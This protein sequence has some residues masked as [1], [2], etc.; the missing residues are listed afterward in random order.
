M[1]ANLQQSSPFD[2]DLG[3]SL[4]L[5]IEYTAGVSTQVCIPIWLYSQKAI[6][7]FQFT[8]YFTSS[9]LACSSLSC[10]SFTSGSFW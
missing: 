1:D 2:Y 9:V 6:D 4:G 5:P 8:L 3:R 7:E 10:G